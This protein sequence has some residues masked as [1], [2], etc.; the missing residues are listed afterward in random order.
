MGES[1]AA[2]AIEL[3]LDEVMA[4]DHQPWENSTYNYENSLGYQILSKNDESTK[5][6]KR[7]Y[8]HYQGIE[9][10]NTKNTEKTMLEMFGYATK[11]ANG[12]YGWDMDFEVLKTIR[13]VEGDEDFRC[14]ICQND[15]YVFSITYR[16][17]MPDKN[18]NISPKRQARVKFQDYV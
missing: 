12:N 16:K 7:L 10:R 2:L 4:P 9:L 6:H 15:Q 13:G 17:A 8:K 18:G 1:M 11:D 5:I 14:Y 3:G